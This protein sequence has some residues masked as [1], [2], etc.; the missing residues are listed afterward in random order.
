MKKWILFLSVMTIVFVSGCINFGS[1][2]GDLP[3]SGG[4]QITEFSAEPKTVDEFDRVSFLLTAENKGGVTAECVKADLYGIENWR[5]Q[6]KQI[7]V[8]I[9]GFRASWEAGSN[10][11]E[12]IGRVVLNPG[13]IMNDLGIDCGRDGLVSS[14]CDA[15]RNAPS[16]NVDF[17]WNKEGFDWTAEWGSYTRKVACNPATFDPYT[18]KWGREEM[19]PRK[20]NMPGEVRIA[21][22][23]FQPPD[24]PEGTSSQYV[25]TGRVTYDYKSTG[26]INIKAVSENEYER[27]NKA[28]T[29]PIT[30]K[31]SNS[32]V[33]L[34]LERG[35]TPIIVEYKDSTRG[36]PD[37]NR[38]TYQFQLQN[39]GDGFPITLGKNGLV[40]GEIKISG[41]GARFEDCLGQSGKTI[42]IDGGI[43][44]RIKLRD[45]GTSRFSCVISID[46]PAWR[47]KDIGTI[48]ILYDLR[49][50]YYTEE[51]RTI[52]VQGKRNY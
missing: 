39:I 5:Y 1:G 20:E 8:N 3:N 49:Y 14:F 41:E 34:S 29:N 48:S 47:S 52:T 12:V 10:W 19:Q 9:G 43:A 17:E 40:M 13:E 35:A 21:E 44:D 6:G 33:I 22:W 23:G 7:V 18:T 16:A 15:L 4:I 32:P 31:R 27:K 51:Q 11:W 42:R 30:E 26:A 38:Y 2:D 24:L 36:G 45:D 28:I 25:V 50:L 46:V 37:K